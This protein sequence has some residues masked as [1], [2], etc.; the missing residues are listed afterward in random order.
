MKC[1]DLYVVAEEWTVGSLLWE[2]LRSLCSDADGQS[3][4]LPRGCGIVFLFDRG[5]VA[6][7]VVMRR[8]AQ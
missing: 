4:S 8:N 3:P 6:I 1:E 7:R 2:K 5:G